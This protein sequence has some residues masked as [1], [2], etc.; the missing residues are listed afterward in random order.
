VKEVEVQLV[1]GFGCKPCDKLETE[2]FA[3]MVDPRDLLAREASRWGLTLPILVD[4]STSVSQSYDALGG[5]HA[6][7]PNHTFVLVD[8][9]GKIRWA[10]DYVSMWVDNESVVQRVQ[11]AAQQ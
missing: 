1:S 3:V 2:V 11:S 8:K 9:T 6:N 4:G 5:M 7:K 10:Q